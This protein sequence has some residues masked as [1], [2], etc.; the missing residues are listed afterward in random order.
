MSTKKD[1]R[2]RRH[3]KIRLT[4]SGNAD[5]PRLFVFR[6]NNH[7]YAQ[8]VDDVKG[9]ILA[10]ISD[11]KIKKGTKV[12]KSKEVGKT[13]AKLALEK[14]IS[15]VVFD[16]GGVVY[17]GRVKAIAEGAREAGLKF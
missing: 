3:K 9:K 10:S 15:T 11:I 8:L 7:I 14:K 12:E 16:R 2:I 17:H 5:R 4:I 6:S 13:I 1:K